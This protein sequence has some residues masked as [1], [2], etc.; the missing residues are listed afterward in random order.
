MQRYTDVLSPVTSELNLTL[1]SF[2]TVILPSSSPIGEVILTDAYGTGLNPAP[3]TPTDLKSGPWRLLSGTILSTLG[4]SLR[5]VNGSG[6]DYA[7]EN[8]AVVAPMLSLG[9][10]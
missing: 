4:S 2:G 1:N 8:K 3:I 10:S 6:T 9:V 7:R 5:T